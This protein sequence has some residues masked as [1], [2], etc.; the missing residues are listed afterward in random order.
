MET[1]LNCSI[2]CRFHDI[3]FDVEFYSHGCSNGLLILHLKT[4]AQFEA[5]YKRLAAGKELCERETKLQGTY[6]YDWNV[7]PTNCC[8]VEV[9]EIAP[10]LP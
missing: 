6:L 9:Q 1:F 8:T 3:R 4:E 5:T 10:L 7:A 2:I